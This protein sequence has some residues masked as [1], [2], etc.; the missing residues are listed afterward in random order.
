MN[1]LK[2]LIE[3]TKSNLL[4]AMRA[5]KDQYPVERNTSNSD[6]HQELQN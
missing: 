5:S 2:M 6:K 1:S 3:L 4:V